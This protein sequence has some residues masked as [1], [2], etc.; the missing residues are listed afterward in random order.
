MKYKQT[1][2][3]GLF[4]QVVLI[5]F[6]LLFNQALM[7]LFFIVLLIISE[8]LLFLILINEKKWKFIE[9]F[10]FVLFSII[11]VF[12]VMMILFP[13]TELRAPLSV[14]IIGALILGMFLVK[15]SS[16]TQKKRFSQLK[17]TDFKDKIEI[18]DVKK[19]PLK[20]ELFAS[21]K[22]SNKYHKPNCGLMN[23]VPKNKIDLYTSKKEANSK[24]LTACKKCLK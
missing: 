17:I 14:E 4:S 6:L 3:F 9:W 2:L 24:G 5:L 8:A 12:I 7:K 16:S 19:H 22:N 1:V 21:A 13:A 20:S 18:F 11:A 23:K 15:F 10:I